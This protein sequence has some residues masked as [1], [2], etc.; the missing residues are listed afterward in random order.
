M[1]KFTFCC[2]PC[3]NTRLRS[4]FDATICLRRERLTKT[5]DNYGNGIGNAV[6]EYRYCCF[7]KELEPDDPDYFG[8][9]GVGVYDLDALTDRLYITVMTEEQFFGSL[10]EALSSHR[11]RFSDTEWGVIQQKMAVLLR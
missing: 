3:N 9:S 11:E 7:A 8:S 6:S 5:L 2:D 1:K 10:A 4:F